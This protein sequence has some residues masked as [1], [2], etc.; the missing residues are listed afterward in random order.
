M[1]EPHPTRPSAMYSRS[2]AYRGGTLRPRWPQRSRCAWPNSQA[3]SWTATSR[4]TWRPCTA[5]PTP[6]HWHR[7]SPGSKP[8]FGPARPPPRPPTGRPDRAQT[9]APHLHARRPQTHQPR[10]HR[11][12]RYGILNRTGFPVLGVRRPRRCRR[13]P[14]AVAAFFVLDPVP[15][16]RRVQVQQRPHMPAGAHLGIAALSQAVAVHPHRPLHEITLVL[17]RCTHEESLPC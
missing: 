8:P 2:S 17:L 10:R 14:N 13:R 6:T 1:A 9:T 11:L 4:P 3:S 15:P 12:G 16:R 5:S 7:Y